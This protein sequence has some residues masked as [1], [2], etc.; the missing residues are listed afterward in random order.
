MHESKIKLRRIIWASHL[1]YNC[2]IT[3]SLLL[4][5]WMEEVQ[6]EKNADL[7]LISF[8]FLYWPFP[9]C[10][11]ADLLIKMLTP[12]KICSISYLWQCVYAW[13]RKELKKQ[14]SR[15]EKYYFLWSILSPQWFLATLN[16]GR[17]SMPLH[18]LINLEGDWVG[19]KNL[20][21]Q[22]TWV[23]G[24]STIHFWLA[25]VHALTHEPHR[26]SSGMSW[27]IRKLS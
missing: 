12:E 9:R 1:F 11:K 3:I 22:E 14:L 4:F 6:H 10:R 20:K 23:C 26:C 18:G 21:M 24:T 25:T 15:Q 27:G 19:R 8:F 13:W 7:S 17:V 5:V 16:Q 2:K